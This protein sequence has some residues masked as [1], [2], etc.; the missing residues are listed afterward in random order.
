MKMRLRVIAALIAAA[1]PGVAFGQVK[2]SA[3]IKT[4][5]VS[6]E[7][8]DCAGEPLRNVLLKLTTEGQEITAS[9]DQD[10]K[11]TFTGVPP[12]R[13]YRAFAPG[14]PRSS[15]GF[16][17]GGSDFE[18]HI[19]L[20]LNCPIRITGRIMGYTGVPIGNQSVTLQEIGRE[21]VTA[22]TDQDGRFAFAT[23]HPN[24]HPS[25][26]IAVNGFSPTAMEIPEKEGPSL[27]VG[28]IILQPIRPI[29][30]AALSRSLDSSKIPAQASRISGRITDASDLPIAEK[31][32]CFGSRTSGTSILE[33]DR[34]GAF[35]FPAVSHNEYEVYVAERVPRFPE[36]L[37]EV[38]KV[39]VSDGQDMD[40]GNIVVQFSSKPENLPKPELAGHIVGPLTVKPLASAIASDKQSVQRPKAPYISA[41]FIGAGGMSIIQNDG[42]IVQPPKETEQ[43]G[44]SSPRISEDRQSVGWLVDSDFCCASYPLSFMLVVYR[45]GKP[46][47]RFT[48]DGRAIF[49]WKFV[50]TGNQ[51]AF[52]QSFPHGDLRT[53]YE[54]RDVDTERLVDQW[55]P[56][57]T[58]KAPKW[59]TGIQ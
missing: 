55:D 47:R 56:D 54:L 58:P 35:V 37:K 36:D 15:I 27:E 3:E 40:L 44:Y 8:L 42:R 51:V 29:P 53:H 28:N 17:V 23:V 7:T 9:T 49:G 30:V 21:N 22:Q 16:A 32:L 14:D 43:V 24:H 46:L 11:F 41:M 10:G 57:D 5:R 18:T 52:E 39:E 2:S 45:P 50:G 13:D 38:G 33:M 12:N 6:G 26:H 25:L 1:T 31:I 34:N 20:G 48:G 4:V 59:A 19:S